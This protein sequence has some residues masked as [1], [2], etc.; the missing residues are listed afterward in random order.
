MGIKYRFTDTEIKKLLDENFVILYDTREQENQHILDYFD[1][2]K[3]KYKKQTVKEGDYTPIIT[4][5]V[6]LGIYRDIYFPVA[7]ERKNGVDELANNLGE[8]TDS[9]DDVRLVRELHR[10]KVKG[11]KIFM[12]VEEKNGMENIINNNYRS[13]YKPKAFVARLKS[14]HFNYLSGLEF[15]NKAYA[16]FEIHKILYYAVME[17]LKQGEI[18]ISPIANES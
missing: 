7:I 15:I 9:R 8:K 17:T 12:I 1:K 14:I 5:N 10:A 18:D 4:K 6:D 16:G 13:M 3:I 2:K 11:I